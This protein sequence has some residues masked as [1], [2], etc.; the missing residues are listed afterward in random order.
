MFRA[1]DAN[2]ADAINLLV[3]VGFSPDVADATNVR[4]LH[5]AAYANALDAARALVAR[6]AEIDPVEENYGGTPFGGAAHY[7]NREVMDFLAPLTTDIWNI[8]YDGRVDRVRELLEAQP[9]RARVDWDEWS[10]LLWLPPHDED[11]A[12]AIAKLF[13]KHGADPHRR[14]SKGGGSPLDRAAALGMTRVAAY[15]RNLP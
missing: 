12:L 14:D 6:G 4:S 3:D 2:R 9:E 13:V 10:P 1:A 11:A 5:R 15:L 8:T 7:L